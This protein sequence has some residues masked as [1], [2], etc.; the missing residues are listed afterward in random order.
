M[1][2]KN[3]N[4]RNNSADQYSWIFPER[5]HN[6]SYKQFQNTQAQ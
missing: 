1:N 6:Y 2:K 4:R 5:H 3:I